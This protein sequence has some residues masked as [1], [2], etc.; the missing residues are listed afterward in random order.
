MA[1]LGDQ[2]GFLWQ[3]VW[4]GFHWL[5][6]SGTV[7]A[8]AV[9]AG[10]CLMSSVAGA[11]LLPAENLTTVTSMSPVTSL[12]HFTPLRLFAVRPVLKT[13][14]LSLWKNFGLDLVV[15]TATLENGFKWHCYYV[16]AALDILFLRNRELRCS[17]HPHSKINKQIKVAFVFTHMPARPLTLTLWRGSTAEACWGKCWV[18]RRLRLGNNWRWQ[19]IHHVSVPVNPAHSPPSTASGSL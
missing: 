17:Q 3:P 4:K 1:I 10:R 6:D 11:R 2:G 13:L 19:L 18:S 16:Q 7:P 14:H 12:P 15:V 9:T 5:S 8:S